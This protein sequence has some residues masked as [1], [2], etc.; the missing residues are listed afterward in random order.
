MPPPLHA[1][2]SP[3]QEPP[4]EADGAEAPTPGSWWVPAPAERRKNVTLVSGAGGHPLL[5]CSQ[6]WGASSPGVPPLL[7]S[8]HSWGTHDPDEHPVLGYPCSWGAPTLGMHLFLGCT[9]SWGTPAPGGHQLLGCRRAWGAPAAGVHPLLGCTYSST[10]NLGVPWLVVG[11]LAGLIPPILSHPAGL[12]PGHRTLPGLPLPAVQLRARRRADGPWAP[13]EQH[14]PGGRRGR[15]RAPPGRG[16]VPPGLRRG[17]S[18]SCAPPPQEYLAVTSVELIVRAS[19]SVT[20]SIKNLVLKD[21]STQ[22]W[23]PQHP[24]PP[25]THCLAAP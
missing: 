5:G 10:L 23:P 1:H 22:V 2:P 12:C 19:V 4:G 24:G 14:L 18:P 16:R 20:S 21:A 11:C 3:L 8:T 25:P 6:F 7:G 9:Q 15:G 17:L 13:L